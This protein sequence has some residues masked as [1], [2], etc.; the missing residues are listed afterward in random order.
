VVSGPEKRWDLGG[1][2]VQKR[3][4][5]YLEAGQGVRY[6]TLTKKQ[7]EGEER[8]TRARKNFGGNRDPGPQTHVQKITSY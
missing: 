1:L 7:V 5:T 6:K 3:G 4:G 8:G 2:G